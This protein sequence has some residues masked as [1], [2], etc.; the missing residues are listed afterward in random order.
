MS[1]ASW[2]TFSR[3]GWRRTAE[4]RSEPNWKALQQQTN[5]FRREVRQKMARWKSKHDEAAA[6][7]KAADEAQVRLSEWEDT[8]D[9]REREWQEHLDREAEKAEAAE[10]ELKSGPVPVASEPEPEPVGAPA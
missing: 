5:E 1:G 3:A 4:R 10:A 7:K 9:T 8:C 6:L 2:P